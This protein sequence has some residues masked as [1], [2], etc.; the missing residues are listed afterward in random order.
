ML[1]DVPAFEL[2]STGIFPYEACESGKG[3]IVQEATGWFCIFFR[4]PLLCFTSLFTDAWQIAGA[5]SCNQ[6]V[7]I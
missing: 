4:S 6:R 1:G 5:V 2:I 7:F 3:K